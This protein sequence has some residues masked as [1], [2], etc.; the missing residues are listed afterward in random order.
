M[1]DWTK[2][3]V[4]VLAG[5][6]SCEREI[7]LI[8][9]KAVSDAL[10]SKGIPAVMLDPMGDFLP[11][12]KDRGPTIVFLALHGTFGEDGTI[13]KILEDEGIPYT[14]S[15]VA[16]SEAAFDKSR[17]QDLFQKADIRIPEFITI[18]QTEPMVLPKKF[19]F[20]IIVKPA[21]SGSSVG[22]SIL[23]KQEDYEKAVFLAFQ[24]SDRVL[25]EQYIQGRELTVGFLADKP[26]PV[27]EVIAQ[28]KFYD[29]EAKYKDN[30][31]RYEFPAKL[32]VDEARLVSELAS[33]AYRVLGCKVMARVD[34]IFAEDKKSYVLEVNTIPGLTHKSLLPKAA[35]AA[36][37]DFPELCV[38][39]LDLS[40]VSWMSLKRTAESGKVKV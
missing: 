24:Y 20:P 23:F 4:V 27:V 15:G 16:A 12:L 3:K 38:R 32:S 30:A 25:V 14:G 19:S 11:D 40:M 5:G 18:E 21:A 35:S 33:Q 22:V 9:G 39:I 34:I 2:R 1:I 6:P 13:Q 17:A 31:T 37:I 10:V 28:R 26:L 8:S 29:Y 36:G 7:S